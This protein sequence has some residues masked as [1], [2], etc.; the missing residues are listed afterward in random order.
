MAAKAATVTIPIVFGV[1][2][3]PVE[4]GLVTSLNRPGGNVTGVANMNIEVAAKRLELLHALVPSASSIGLLVNPSS[5]SLAQSFE[6]AVMAAARTLGRKLHVLKASNERD[7]EIAFS[8]FGRLRVALVIMPDV[9]FN[10]WSEKIARLTVQ[11]S[12]AAIYQYRKF[13]E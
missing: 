8:S 9:F 10:S 2:A 3:D 12:V 1:A 4:L 11:H 6:R 5:P 7:I 13:V